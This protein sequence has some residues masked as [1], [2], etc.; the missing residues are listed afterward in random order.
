MPFASTKDIILEVGPNTE[1]SVAVCQHI[2][3]A[4]SRS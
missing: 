1:R 2:N 3:T 4:C